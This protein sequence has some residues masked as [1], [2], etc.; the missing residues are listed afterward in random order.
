MINKCNKKMI[1]IIGVIM[2]FKRIIKKYQ[3][4]NKILKSKIRKSKI[5]LMIWKFLKVILNLSQIIKR[6]F[7]FHLNSF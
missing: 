7:N 4:N 6:S 2:K 1:L 3:K 5:N